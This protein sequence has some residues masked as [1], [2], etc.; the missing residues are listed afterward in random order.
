MSKTPNIDLL[1]RGFGPRAKDAVI[2]VAIPG[3]QSRHAEPDRGFDSAAAQSAGIGDAG[4]WGRGY[5]RRPLRR[6]FADKAGPT[7]RGTRRRGPLARDHENRKGNRLSSKA[8]RGW[9]RGALS[10]PWG[11]GQ[12]SGPLFSRRSFSREGPRCGP[13]RIEQAVGPFRRLDHSRT[14]RAEAIIA[15]MVDCG[16]APP[17]ARLRRPRFAPLV[18]G[19][20]TLSADDSGLDLAHDLLQRQRDIPGSGG[21]DPGTSVGAGGRSKGPGTC[22]GRGSFFT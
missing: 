22:F 3:P 8:I 13:M 9:S 10:K 18:G 19:N 11:S 21:R 7:R 12:G 20:R 17:G 2:G 5:S 15:G 4:V 1:D 14:A 6:E 16:Q